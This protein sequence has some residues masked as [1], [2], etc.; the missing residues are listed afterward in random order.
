MILKDL[1]IGAK[2]R[3]EKSSVVFLVAAHNHTGYTGTALVTDCAIKLAAID[4]AE[5]GNPNQAQREFGN[6]FYPLSNI[7]QWL[8]AD[9]K[10]WYKP[11]HEF[12]APPVSENLD[13][14]RLEFYEVPFYSNE[15][16]FTGD[17]SYKDAPGFLT[18]FSP[19]FV[20]SI[21]EVVVPCHLDPVPGKVHYGPP[22]P[23]DLKAKVFLL[24]APELGLEE[25]Q[26]VVEGFRFPLFNDGRMRVVAPTA[27]AIGKPADYVYDDC[28]LY[29]WLRTAVRGSS[30]ASFI[31]DSD[32]R[33]G[34]YKCSPVSPRMPNGPAHVR[35]VCGIRP[36]LNLNSGVTVS[37]EPD[38]NGIYTLVF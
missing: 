24:S 7:H 37:K 22:V 36:A 6:N 28:S 31:Y 25:A 33:I 35:G 14:G 29:Y 4:A 23:Y 10:N 8:N 11:S 34:D 17:F 15:A 38:G 13:H 2:V 16:K 12:D 1:P 5:P 19:A 21:H 20:A 26:A 9:E 27:A 32:H 30:T 3:E 18:W